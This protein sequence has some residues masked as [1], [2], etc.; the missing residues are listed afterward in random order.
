L[1]STNDS[2]FA[3]TTGS[4]APV[5]LHTYN[6]RRSPNP[7]NSSPSSS[8]DIELTVTNPQLSNS[9]SFSGENS[10]EE[11]PI[12]DTSSLQEERE[13]REEEQLREPP[14]EKSRDCVRDCACLV[15]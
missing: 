1:T 13:E 10:Q 9:S 2:S 5:T 12:E 14:T 4:F 6:S 15:M 3:S 8:S 11:F 7:S